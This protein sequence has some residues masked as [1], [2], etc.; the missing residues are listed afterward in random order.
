MGTA[1]HTLSG[2]DYTDPN[3]FAR[4]RDTIL[5]REWFY[6][7]RAD[8][9]ANA[10]QWLTVDI[11]GESI[12]VIRGRDDRLRAFY[13]VCRHRGSLLCEG[14][15]GQA[16]STIRCN[17]HAWCYDYDGALVATPKVEEGEVDPSQLA[18]SPV[19]VDVWE[20]FL[21][22]NLDRNKPRPL[23]DA[24]GENYDEPLAFE[25][26]NLGELAI[27]ARTVN[28][29][30]AN[31]KIVIENYNECLHCSTVHPEL[32]EVMPLYRTGWVAE[33]GRTDGGTSLADGG[34]GYT[35]DGRSRLA[36]LPGRTDIEAHSVYGGTLY[37]NMFLDLAPTVAIAT[38]IL[39]IS[40]T[41]TKII[42]EYLFHPD[43]I[44]KPDFDPSDVVNFSELVA[45]QDYM[46]CQWVQR[47]VSSRAF[48]HGYL[49][50]KD[51]YVAEFNN[52]Y[53]ADMARG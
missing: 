16:K 46:V 9:I 33:E 14:E 50:E 32:V 13:N 4:E 27:G 20:G 40:P 47:G 39:P 35:Q 30:D 22:V 52:R 38:S 28:E 12:L 29:V 3:V 1:Q 6:V 19:H 37:P 41:K 48:T 24:I 49:A 43:E 44:A 26:F 34:T 31:W 5:Y 2:T 53:R 36:V 23:R 11:A 8:T 42:T 25:R 7:A 10:G 45:S 18:L 17:Y 21:F 15:S 51:K